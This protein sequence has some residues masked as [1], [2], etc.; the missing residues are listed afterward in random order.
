M[1]SGFT[2][3]KSTDSAEG[4]K[5][6][7]ALSPLSGELFFLK[8]VLDNIPDPVFVIGLDY[9][10]LLQNKAAGQVGT[11]GGNPQT[12]QEKALSGKCY[13]VLHGRDNA[14]DERHHFCPVREIRATGV[15]FSGVYEFDCGGVKVYW[16]IHSAPLV[17][18]QG[19]LFAVVQTFRE[20]RG[21]P[22][23]SAKGGDELRL[24]H[25]AYH[26]HLTQLPNRL[27]FEDRLQ[28]TIKRARRQNSQFALLFVDLDNFKEINDS[29]G[30]HVGDLLLQ[31]VSQLMQLCLRQSDTVA[32]YAGDEFVIILERMT[33]KKSAAGVAEKIIA[34][35]SRSCVMDGVELKVSASVGIAIYPEDGLMAR[36]LLKNA[37]AAMYTVKE[38]CRGRL[39]FFSSETCARP[40]TLWGAT[41]ELDQLEI[42]YQ[43]QYDLASHKMTAMEALLRWRHPDDGLL[44]PPAFLETFERNGLNVLIG[45][46]ILLMVCKQIKQWKNSGSLVVVAVNLSESQFYQAGLVDWVSEALEAFSLPPSCLE[47]EIGESVLAIEREI[48]VDRLAA[49]KK[50]GVRLV[51]DNV[52]SE[53]VLKEWLAWN[54]FDK[55]KIDQSVVRRMTE[56]HERQTGIPPVFRHA[57]QKYHEVTAVGVETMVQLG[58]LRSRGCDTVQGYLFS[59]PLTAFGAGDVLANVQ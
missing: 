36:E 8:T 52:S 49:L 57:R 27:L 55:V 51:M 3:N 18:A 30:H 32:R 26:D 58:I 48:A 9:Q 59:H 6:T 40:K 1:P 44:D 19:K 12:S 50:L 43:P 41:L 13:A 28:Q 16:E 56:R 25:L 2:E 33:V 38:K 5:R 22:A 14:C 34:A 53:R 23:G 31:R 7:R 17:N 45:R 11:R 4:Q 10:I 21:F 24:K 47:L 35:L 37:D 39:Q 29:F 15:E 42:F 20:V 46:H 54:F